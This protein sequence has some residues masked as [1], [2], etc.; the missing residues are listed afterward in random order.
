MNW[1]PNVLMRDK[2]QGQGCT[3]KQQVSLSK[4]SRTERGR[5]GGGSVRNGKGGGAQWRM[6]VILGG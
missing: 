6:A 1:P 3:E 2:V 5:G 4:N